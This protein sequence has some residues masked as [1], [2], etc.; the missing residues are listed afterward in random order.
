MPA[1]TL[2]D[3]GDGGRMTHTVLLVRHGEVEGG[4]PGALLGRTDSHLSRVGRDQAE[5]L[6]ALMPMRGAVFLCSPL[7]RCRETAAIA[8]AGW[9]A[10][11][12]IDRDLREVDF[13]EWEGLTYGEVEESHPQLAKAWADPLPDFTFPGG[14][15]LKDFGHR[16]EQVAD[17][18]AGADV[19]S[20][21]AF[22]HGGVIR[23]LICHFLGL[24]LRDYLLFEVT[25][26]SITTLRLWDGRGVLA[27]MWAPGAECLPG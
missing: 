18:L 12:E 4:R 1:V 7:A 25:P 11:V 2:D 13:G 16:V 26:G 27:A 21:V 14:E 22:T 23:T 8:V 20:V 5:R 6:A 19:P 24:P 15:S 17:R 10:D 9:E 3:V